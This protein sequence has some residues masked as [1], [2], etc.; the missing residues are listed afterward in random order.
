M[1]ADGIDDR[2]TL[3]I[4]IERAI[5]EDLG[6]PAPPHAI[7]LGVHALERRALL[8]GSHRAQRHIT[9]AQVA[10]PEAHAVRI[11]AELRAQL[12]ETAVPRSLAPLHA[13]QAH[14]RLIARGAVQVQVDV[15]DLAQRTRRRELRLAK[16]QRE[17]E[18]TRFAA[19]VLL[20]AMPHRHAPGSLGT[21]I[22]VHDRFL[23]RDVDGMR[24]AA[25]EPDR[26]I[27]DAH[28]VGFQQRAGVVAV[29]HTRLQDAEARE[30]IA[31]DVA[32]L[33]HHV[34]A[35]R[36]RLVQ[37]ER[38]LIR[39][40][41]RA[42]AQIQDRAHDREH[43][44]ARQREQR[45]PDQLADRPAHGLRDVLDDLLDLLADRLDHAVVFVPPRAFALAR[46]LRPGRIRRRR[47]V[48][49][50]GRFRGRL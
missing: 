39:H 8:P 25:Q 3:A 46:R 23:D 13:P 30:R 12:I 22:E 19:A 5:V 14:A 34:T 11:G 44:Q 31:L 37:D 50:L 16:V 38:Q 29:S 49:R 32:Q 45:D 41:L 1:V 6:E 20:G 40:E 36:E 28:L 9:G 27:I 21:A 33:Q 7:D 18:R 4:D 35:L 26:R 43:D 24:V 17:R 2:G 47:T 42:V 15:V 48:R 10:D